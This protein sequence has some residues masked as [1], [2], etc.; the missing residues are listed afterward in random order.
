M[1]E[2]ARGVVRT[3]SLSSSMPRFFNGL[4]DLDE[5]GTVEVLR[6]IQVG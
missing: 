4:G 6:L 3:R 5:L 1:G 2:A